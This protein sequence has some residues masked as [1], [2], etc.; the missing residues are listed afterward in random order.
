[1]IHFDMASVNGISVEVAMTTNKSAI[2][3]RVQPDLRGF[4]DEAA[5]AQNRPLSNLIETIVVEWAK[6][7]G[8]RPKPKK[9]RA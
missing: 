4:L 3:F 9:P 6:Q 8:Y 7:N 1:M 2:L 5:A